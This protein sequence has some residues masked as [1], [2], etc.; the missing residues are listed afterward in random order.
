MFMARPQKEKSYTPIAKEL[1]EAII[2]FGFGRNEL[3]IK[4]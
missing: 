1:L 4:F 2:K 3:E